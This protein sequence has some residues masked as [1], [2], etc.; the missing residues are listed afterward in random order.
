MCLLNDDSFRHG[1]IVETH[2]TLWQ[3]KITMDNL[4]NCHF[5]W[6]NPLWILMVIAAIAVLYVWGCIGNNTQRKIHGDPAFPNSP[7]THPPDLQSIT[8]RQVRLQIRSLVAHLRDLAF[9]SWSYHG[10]WRF[11]KLS[12]GWETLFVA[13]NGSPLNAHGMGNISSECEYPNRSK[14]LPPNHWIVK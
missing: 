2:I 6:V 5:S 13:P 7:R 9:F 12:D 1:T 10:R 3:T 11:P 4:Q 14:S 8:Q